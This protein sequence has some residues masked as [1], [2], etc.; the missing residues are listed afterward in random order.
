MI[1]DI[2]YSLWLIFGTALLIAE[3]FLAGMTVF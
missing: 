1:I 2:A 3:M